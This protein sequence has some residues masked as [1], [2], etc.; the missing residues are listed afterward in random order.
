[1]PLYQFDVRD[2]HGREKKSFLVGINRGGEE[3][4]VREARHRFERERED[5]D[6]I[7]LSSCRLFDGPTYN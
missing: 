1:M 6:Q 4:A 7:D 5:G 3:V 2:A